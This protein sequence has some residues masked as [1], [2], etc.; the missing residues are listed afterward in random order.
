MKLT[1]Y[2]KVTPDRQKVK[3]ELK[4]KKDR[5]T[6]PIHFSENVCSWMSLLR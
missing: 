2:Y 1:V 3:F 6:C 4:F 5:E